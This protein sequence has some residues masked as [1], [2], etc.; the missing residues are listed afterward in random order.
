MEGVRKP[1]EASKDSCCP[2]DILTEHLPEYGSTLRQ[3]A[4]LNLPGPGYED[5]KCMELE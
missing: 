5:E 4:P 2:A 3:A 1:L